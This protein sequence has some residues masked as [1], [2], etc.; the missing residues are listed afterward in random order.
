MIPQ[1]SINI[2]S[3]LGNNVQEGIESLGDARR[4]VLSM[5][6]EITDAELTFLLCALEN[7]NDFDKFYSHFVLR[8]G[9]ISSLTRGLAL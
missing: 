6:E 9:R 4:F 5:K 8:E 1:R 7:K 3:F 2:L